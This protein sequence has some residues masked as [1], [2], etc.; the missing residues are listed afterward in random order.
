MNS[1]GAIERA[2]P[3]NRPGKLDQRFRSALFFVMPGLAGV[4]TPS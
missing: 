3:A 2:D 1:T 4:A